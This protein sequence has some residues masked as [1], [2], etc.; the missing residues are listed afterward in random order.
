[1][2]QHD[3]MLSRY[4][5]A[6]SEAKDELGEAIDIVRAGEMSNNAMFTIGE[7]NG[8]TVYKRLGCKYIQGDKRVYAEWEKEYAELASPLSADAEI[9][10]KQVSDNEDSF[11]TEAA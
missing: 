5:T 11:Y 2:R 8:R 10:L 9:T 6:Y 1:M 4:A 3:L 7:I